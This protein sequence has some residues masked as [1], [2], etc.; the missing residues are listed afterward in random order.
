MTTNTSSGE[1]YGSNVFTWALIAGAA[2]V[3]YA[4]LASFTSTPPVQTPTHTVVAADT[5]TKTS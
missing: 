4:S 5:N 3:L 2:F 1:V